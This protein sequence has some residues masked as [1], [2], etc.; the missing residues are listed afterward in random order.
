M[1]RKTPRTPIAVRKKTRRWLSTHTIPDVRNVARDL[2]N[3]GEDVTELLQAIDE[4]ESLVDRGRLRESRS[5]V[6]AES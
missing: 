2:E 4:L 5:A 1:P 3:V 6:T